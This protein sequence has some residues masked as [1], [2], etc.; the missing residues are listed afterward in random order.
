VKRWCRAAALALIWA[1]S[2]AATPP[3]IHEIFIQVG[4]S[5]VRALCTDGQRRVVL[6]HGEH[7]TAD[8]WRRVLEELDGLVGACA[9]DRVGSGESGPRPPARGWYELLDELRRIHLALGFEEQYVLVGQGLGGLYARAYAADRPVD[10]AGLLLVDP[11]HEDLPGRL[12]AGMPHDEWEAWVERRRHPNADGVEE[13]AIGDRVRSLRLPQ[14]PL[15]VITA[16]VRRDGDGWSQRFVNEGF[17]QVHEAIV[18]GVEFARHIPAQGS[19]PDVQLDDP[20][21]VTDEI[22]R[23]AK[24]R[25]AQRSRRGM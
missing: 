12:R 17:R 22:L 16:T 2:S 13:E 21:L 18:Q 5:R 1:A 24:A 14:L 25:S 3:E 10:L 11:L 20:R 23:M 4:T 7:D 8:T 9:Y 6:M 15:A 19:G